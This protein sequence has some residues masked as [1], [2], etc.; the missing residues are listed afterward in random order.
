MWLPPSVCVCDQHMLLQHEICCAIFT[1]PRETTNLFWW[2]PDLSP[3]ITASPNFSQHFITVLLCALSCVYCKN[4]I[5]LIALYNHSTIYPVVLPTW[6]NNNLE[7]YMMLTYSV[8]VFC[9]I[10]VR[11]YSFR[12]HTWFF[13]SCSTPSSP[14]QQSCNKSPHQEG[15]SIQF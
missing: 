5:Y 10:W 6:K 15:Y 7:P 13:L 9:L 2:S 12:F 14:I 8:C 3:S 4:N 1:L 11:P